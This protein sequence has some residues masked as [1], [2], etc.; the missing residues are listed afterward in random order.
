M[1]LVF[2]PAVLWILLC[3]QGFQDDFPPNQAWECD[4]CPADDGSKRRIYGMVRHAMYTENREV[5]LNFD[6]S[7]MDRAL[8]TRAKVRVK[9]VPRDKLGAIIMPNVDNPP[10]HYKD[11]QYFVVYSPPLNRD[12][13][14]LLSMQDAEVLDSFL[15]HN[16]CWMPLHDPPVRLAGNSSSSDD[17]SAGGG[18]NGGDASLNVRMQQHV[19]GK[20]YMLSAIFIRLAGHPYHPTCLMYSY[21][22]D[23]QN[24]E[25]CPAFKDD[26]KNGD[27]AVAVN[28]L[29]NIG[30]ANAL[31]PLVEHLVGAMHNMQILLTPRA[32]DNGAAKPV[33]VMVNGQEKEASGPWIAWADPAECGIDTFAWNPWNC[34]FV[35]LSKCNNAELHDVKFV[36]HPKPDPQGGSDYMSKLESWKGKREQYRDAPHLGN[37]WEFA[38]MIS[39]VQRSNAFTRARLRISLK[40]LV[41]LRPTGF[42]PTEHHVHHKHAIKLE[43]CLGMHVRHG[44]SQNDER[45]GKLDRS[46]HAHIDCAKDLAE[47]MGVKNI[48]LATDDNKLFS[49]APQKYP[50]YGWYGQYRALKN[51]TGGSFGY[52][53]ERSMQQEIANLLV[54]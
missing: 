38:R 29:G 2:L 16:P 9:I 42:G 31:H 14:D 15:L 5:Y 26:I 21:I 17:I 4:D 36:E 35:S 51:F 47:S 45:G 49:E 25:T 50:Q 18:E 54:S 32:W 41:S 20:E 24:P 39:F 40:N 19:Q 7:W 44:D 13:A 53:N 33:K 10:D 52:H 30:W 34:F 8:K 12:S 23:K 27:G 28:W 11:E 1:R 48:Y 46:L 22:T 43:P 37:E 3:A 6:H